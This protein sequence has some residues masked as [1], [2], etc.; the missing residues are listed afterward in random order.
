MGVISAEV[1]LAASWSSVQAKQGGLQVGICAARAQYCCEARNKETA[2][3]N[4]AMGPVPEDPGEG[5]V[6]TGPEGK[7]QDLG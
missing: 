4:R 5:E 1:L 2:P 3:S 6:C 7:A